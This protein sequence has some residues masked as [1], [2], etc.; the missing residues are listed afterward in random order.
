[1]KKNKGILGA[2]GAIGL[3]GLTALNPMP[4]QI[5][6]NVQTPTEIAQGQQQKATPAP[7]AQGHQIQSPVIGGIQTGGRWDMGIPPKIYG[8][9]YVK[10]GTHKRTNKG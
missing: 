7:I 9:N 5:V 1:M 8:Q 4:T 6:N 3:A 10:K 2:I